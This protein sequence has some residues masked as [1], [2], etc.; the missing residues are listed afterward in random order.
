[1]SLSTPIFDGA[2]DNSGVRR[3]VRGVRGQIQQCYAAAYAH[4]PFTGQLRVRLVINRRGR[5]S[6]A[7]VT[8]PGGSGLTS[9]VRRAVTGPTY[10]SATVSDVIVTFNV[11]LQQ[12]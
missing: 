11:R 3:A 1:V 9:C 12:R 2:I 8:G 6:S 5:A 10:P 7:N 4:S